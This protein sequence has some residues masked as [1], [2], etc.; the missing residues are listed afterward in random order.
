MFRLKSTPVRH[1]TVRFEPVDPGRAKQLPSAAIAEWA[2]GN[3]RIR[4]VW[5]FCSR[6]G[7]VPA[8]N[9][10]IDIALELQ[11][12]ADSEETIAVWLANCDKWRLELQTRIGRTVELDWLDSDGASRTTRAESGEVQMLIYDSNG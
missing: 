12:V 11:P 7:D 4:R 1:A 2:A 8:S 10:G 5:L 6:A 3:P 9:G